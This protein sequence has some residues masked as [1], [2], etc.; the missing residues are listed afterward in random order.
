MESIGKHLEGWKEKVGFKEKYEQ[1][2]KELMNDP[3]VQK[4]MEEFELNEKNI[5]PYLTEIENVRVSHENC[6]GCTGLNECSN[7]MRGHKVLIKKHNRA[8]VFFNKPCGFMEE[9]NNRRK[10]QKMIQSYFVSEELRD[11]SFKDIEVGSNE[12]KRYKIKNFLAK[13]A[14]EVEPGKDGVGLYLY[15]WFGSGK[16][17]MMWALINFLS[18]NRGISSIIVYVPD[19]VREIKSSIGNKEIN[20]E[21][22]IKSLKEIPILVLDDIGS[23]SLS[24]WVRDEVIAPL[25]QHRVNAKLPTLY[26]SNNNLNDLRDFFAYTSANGKEYTKADRIMQR[27]ENYC[28]ILHTED[29]NRRKE[30]NS[31]SLTR[32]E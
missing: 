14:K 2:K 11:I 31:G 6:K 19:F 26:T 28:N 8:P 18:K 10:Q 20:I 12:K 13:Y 5:G 4:I 3:L 1:T 25:L 23:D 24:P 7:K 29:R 32:I 9:E 22:K 21:D 30:K 17:F 16:T 27:I 15:G